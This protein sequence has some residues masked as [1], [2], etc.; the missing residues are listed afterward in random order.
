MVGNKILSSL[1]TPYLLAAHTLNNTPS[2][3]V[4]LFNDHRFTSD[5]LIKQADLALYQAKAAGR[6]TLCFFNADRQSTATTPAA[7]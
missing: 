2:I 5:E 4:T 3:G 6:N 7:A 1:N